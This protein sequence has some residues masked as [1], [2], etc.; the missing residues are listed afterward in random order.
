MHATNCRN[1]P[2]TETIRPDTFKAEESASDWRSLKIQKIISMHQNPMKTTAVNTGLLWACQSDHE[3]KHA[4]AILRRKYWKN[5]RKMY[6]KGRNCFR[7]LMLSRFFQYFCSKK[8][9]QNISRQKF[10]FVTNALEKSHGSLVC[11]CAVYMCYKPM[12]PGTCKR[13]DRIK[14]RTFCCDAIVF[15]VKALIPRKC[16]V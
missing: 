12:W 10:P 4:H 1:A 7:L 3:T 16:D 5:V 2:I 13:R 9:L 8:E 6:E 15:G 11:V 14:M